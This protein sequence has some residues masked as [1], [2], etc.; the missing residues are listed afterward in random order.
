M[1]IWI[2]LS[3]DRDVGTV[4]PFFFMFHKPIRHNLWDPGLQM[5]DFA[6]NF[7][8]STSNSLFV[9][10]ISKHR[11]LTRIKTGESNFTSFKYPIISPFTSST[12]AIMSGHL[13]LSSFF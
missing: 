2:E 7:S 5:I 12:L 13:P 8:A 4:N 11:L 3:L 10:S 1:Q 6:G 9:K